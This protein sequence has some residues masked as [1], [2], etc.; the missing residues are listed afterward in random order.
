MATFQF[1]STDAGTTC[2]FDGG[3]L[4]FSAALAWDPNGTAAALCIQLPYAAPALGTHVGDQVTVG[5]TSDGNTVSG[6]GSDCAVTVREV[7]DGGVTRDD[8]GKPT[9]FS[10]TLQDDLT[11][12]SADG[13]TS[14]NC[15]LPCSV[16]WTIEGKP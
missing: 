15:G 10:G 14:C 13:G 9:K 4:A 6:C 8:G 7:L 3:T 2:A 1:E 12:A 11:G 16:T 5:S